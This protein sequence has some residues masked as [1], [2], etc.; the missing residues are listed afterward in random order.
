MLATVLLA[1][2]PEAPVVPDELAP[3]D[4]PEAFELALLEVV[5]VE[6][7]ELLDALAVEPLL[8]PQSHARNALPSALQVCPPSQPPGPMHA[9]D[10]PGLQIR[11]PL[12]ELDSG[13]EEH[14]AQAIKHAARRTVRIMESSRRPEV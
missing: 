13:E 5:P 14:D 8:P 7:L 3:V 9:T 11:P 4:E 10:S 12:E 1:E 2:V 6:P